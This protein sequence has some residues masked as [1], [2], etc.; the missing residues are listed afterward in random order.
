MYSQ[1]P[2]CQAIF[3]VSPTDIDAH[4]GLVRCGYCNSVFH[5][6]T[7][8]VDDS[9]IRAGD[10]GTGGS[11][12]TASSDDPL[13]EA[14]PETPAGVPQTGGEEN[15]YRE[16]DES[17]A[18]PPPA[19]REEPGWTVAA[20]DQ[21]DR[22]PGSRDEMLIEPVLP[23]PRIAGEQVPDEPWW[24]DARREEQ[25]REEQAREEQAR[26]EQAREE[27][28]REEPGEEGSTTDADTELPGEI[29]EEITIEAPPV[30]WNAFDDELDEEGPRSDATRG[31]GSGGIDGTG[32]A[33]RSGAREGR[34]LVRP[35]RAPPSDEPEPAAKPGRRSPLRSPYRERDIRMVEL[36]KPR[37]FKTA[38]LSL[39]TVL[40]A[41]L[42]VWQ[43]KTYYLSDLAQVTVLR[44]YIEWV[45]RPLDC[46]L[47]PRRDFARINL[48]GTSIDVNPERPGALEITASLINRAAF[49]Q[50]YPPLRVTLTDREGRVVGRRTF[51]P[52][53]YRG[54]GDGELLPTSEVSDVAI[55]LAQPSR[56]AVGYEVELMAPVLDSGG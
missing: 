14:T 10:E 54:G 43:V 28:A 15:A 29:I 4:R 2:K 50:P 44:P 55:N 38:I 16:P 11:R 30:L 24:D 45:C 41:L 9:R 39:L 22:A 7:N 33:P 42:M 17:E 25:A 12:A 31:N 37:P 23:D 1:C 34:Q 52:S 18:K 27:Q 48:V 40:L 46:M 19:V 32:A 6:P 51:L 49:P 20:G 21:A 26:E 36:P 53:E 13:I 8:E 3:S 35:G 5:A 47:P 56:N